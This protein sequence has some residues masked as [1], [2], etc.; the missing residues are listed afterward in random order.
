MPAEIVSDKPAVPG[1]VVF[2]IGCRMNADESAAALNK[3]FECR[4][5]P[6]VEDVTGC[7]EENHHPVLR[8]VLVVEDGGVF[9]GV[10]AEVVLLAQ[11]PDGG[12]AVGNRIVPITR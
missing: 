2:G 7:V 5:L 10:N 6:G 3:L 12:D 1:P 9:A 8:Q 4:L 11:R